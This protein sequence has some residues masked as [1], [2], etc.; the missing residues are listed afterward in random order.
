MN[1]GVTSY[2]MGIQMCRKYIIRKHMPLWRILMVP[3]ALQWCF[4]YGKWWLLDYSIDRPFMQVMFALLCISAFVT[5]YCV[6]SKKRLILR[7]EF[8]GGNLPHELSGIS[9]DMSNI[10]IG[11]AE[12]DPED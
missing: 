5:G 7:E 3:I 4:D 8:L 11:R 10:M 1:H 6:L 2:I 12:E 9:V